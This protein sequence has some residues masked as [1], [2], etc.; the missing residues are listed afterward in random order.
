M[1]YSDYKMSVPPPAGTGTAAFQRDEKKAPEIAF[2][3]R[4]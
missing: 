3:G 1:V 2:C 4:R